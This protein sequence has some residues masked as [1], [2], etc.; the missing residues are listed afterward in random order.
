MGYNFEKQFGLPHSCAGKWDPPNQWLFQLAHVC[1]LISYT[2]PNNIYGVLFLHGTLI[3]GNHRTGKWSKFFFKDPSKKSNLHCPYYRFPWLDNMGLCSNLCSGHLWL[4][5]GI[6][7][8]EH[9]ASLHRGLHASSQTLLS[10][11]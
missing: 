3:L 9:R 11:D 1:L 6:S 8:C 10:G 2:A 7:H 4:E 5:P